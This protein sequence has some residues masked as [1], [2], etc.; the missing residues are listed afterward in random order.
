MVN[1]AV[2]FRTG[3]GLNHESQISNIMT[4]MLLALKSRAL[5]AEAITAPTDTLAT[6]S[7]NVSSAETKPRWQLI[8]E[9]LES[10]SGAPTDEQIQIAAATGINVPSDVPAPVA[11]VIL[12]D[13]LS[14]VLFRKLRKKVDIPEALTELEGD[15]EVMEPAFLRTG[16]TEEVSAWFQARYMLKTARGLRDL[17]PSEGDVVSAPSKLSS[18]RVISSIGEDGRVHFRGRPAGRAW[19]NNLVMVEPVGSPHHAEAVAAVDAALRNASVYN[20]ISHERFVALEEFALEKNAPEPEAVRALEELLE[21]GERMEAPF[22]KLLEMYPALLA[23]TVMGGWKT[24]VMPQKRLGSEYIPDFLVLGINSVGPQ[25]VTV[26]IEAARHSIENN[27]GTLS[28]ATRH[29]V[30]QIP[31]WRDWMMNNVA[32]AQTE[33]GLH[34]ITNRAP[35]LVIIGRDHP[36][37]SRQPA[38][39]Q[40]SED[41]RI[42]IHSWDWLLR[43]AKKMMED[44]SQVSDFATSN[45]ESLAS[46]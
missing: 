8:A 3:D 36:S 39:A 1:M 12:Q 9:K 28:G 15:L 25:W 40:S 21:S 26:E 35:G 31:D 24:F 37:F 11:A 41:A 5:G 45:V 2:V 33:L 6:M 22:Q 14:H 23:S 18:N 38:R 4:V 46:S 30:K 16:A 19:P 20:S 10:L 34:G 13:G 7:K 29:G 43:H 42:D 17:K 27:D 32:Y 44:A